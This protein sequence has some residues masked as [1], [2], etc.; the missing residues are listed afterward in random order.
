M[1][2]APAENSNLRL[3]QLLFVT[4]TW[5]AALSIGGLP[6]RAFC[7]SPDEHVEKSPAKDGGAAA[8][9]QHSI[10]PKTMDRLRELDRTAQE[11]WMRKKMGDASGMPNDPIGYNLPFE[12]E[13][14]PV[15]E[16]DHTMV[17]LSI[18]VK[19]S[20]L[21]F[22]VVMFVKSLRQRRAAAKDATKEN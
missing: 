3:L 9:L 5:C 13:R 4:A 18:A 11:Q 21:V 16:R 20:L 6:T 14:P 8:E 19:L 15:E 2:A 22:I 7:A 17:L 1:V 12:Y 10:D